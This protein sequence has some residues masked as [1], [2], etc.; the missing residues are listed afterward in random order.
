MLSNGSYGVHF[1][2]AT[3]IILHPNLFHFDYIE[4]PKQN[5]NP[6]AC[7]ST[8][9]AAESV[10]DQISQFDFF[11]Y[12]E[13]INKKVVLLQHFKS[14]LDG[15]QKFKPLEFNFTKEN[16]PTRQEMADEQLCYVKKWKRAKKAILLRNTNKIIQVMFQDMSEL[17]I[18]SGSGYVTFV[19]SKQE[20]KTVPI[21]TPDE[22]L[23][24]MDKSL[25]KRLQYAKEILV[26][27]MS[28]ASMP[29]EL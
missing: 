17:I 1:N 3:K 14:Y 2:D 18:C 13:S 6:P 22:N 9:Q 19:N 15:N 16:A 25:F 4:R 29:P 5:G 8:G 11:N 26:Q 27:M 21:N 24:Y 20:I 10:T 28:A 23:E 12:P 7:T